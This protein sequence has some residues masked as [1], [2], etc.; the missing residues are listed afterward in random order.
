MVKQACIVRAIVRKWVKKSTLAFV[1]SIDVAAQAFWRIG[2][3][4]KVQAIFTVVYI[5]KN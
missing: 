4:T 2:N 5:C 3:W 1:W